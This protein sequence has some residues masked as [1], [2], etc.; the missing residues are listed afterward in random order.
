MSHL[1]F[2]FYYK[3]TNFNSLPVLLG[4]KTEKQHNSDLIKASSQRASLIADYTIEE[5]CLVLFLVDEI[6]F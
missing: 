2:P 6:T 5:V 1:E 3:P 4:L